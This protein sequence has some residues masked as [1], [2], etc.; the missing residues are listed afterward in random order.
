MLN[1]TRINGLA[2][3]AAEKLETAGFTDLSTGNWSGDDVAASVVYYQLADDVATAEQVAAT[4]GLSTVELSPEVATDGIVVVL[5]Q[6]YQ[7]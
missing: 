3:G 4:L 1:S 5:A 6:D 7:A 2:A